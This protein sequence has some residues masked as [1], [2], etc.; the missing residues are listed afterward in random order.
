M[1]AD[2]GASVIKVEPPGGAGFRGY[3]HGKAG[4]SA[5]WAS[6]NRGKHSLV[7]DLKTADGLA[8]M[9]GLIESADVLVENWRPRVAGSPGLSQEQ[10][11]VWNPRLVRLSIT[12][13]GTTGPLVNAPAFD[14]LIQARTG[15]VATEA[16]HGEPDISPFWVVDKVVATFGAQAMLAALYAR[17]RTGRGSHVSLPM[18]DVMTYFNFPDLFQHRT[19]IGD[20]AAWRPNSSPVFKTAD[21]H[22]V[23]APVSGRHI[24]SALKAVGK[25]EWKEELRAIQSPPE[26]TLRFYELLRPVMAT[27]TCDEWLQS[28]E[29]LDVPAAKVF[30]LDERLDDVQVA[31]N[32]LYT[33]AD[34]PAGPIRAV[35]YPASF[36]GKTFVAANGAPAVNQHAREI[37]SR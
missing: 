14:S 21:G 13:F 6:A 36:D 32:R 5:L 17:E 20:T 3:G 16:R 31:N 4:L 34:S 7:L 22:L 37:L 10:V 2:L 29:E 15:I 33:T 24:S 25:I 30:T 35:R 9:R 18:I 28:F 27:R 11:Q 1:L 26:M 23:I 12:G 8:A 19:F